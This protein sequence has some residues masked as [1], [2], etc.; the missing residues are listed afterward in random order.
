MGEVKIEGGRS[1][2][3]KYLTVSSFLPKVQCSSGED[4][5]IP[6]HPWGLESTSLVGREWSSQPLL[7]L[8]GIFSFQAKV[9]KRGR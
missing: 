3:W 9:L 2:K 5:E 1:V 4:Q 8:V 7:S 6:S